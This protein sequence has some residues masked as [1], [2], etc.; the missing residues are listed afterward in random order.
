MVRI[1]LVQP[2]IYDFNAF[3]LWVRPLGWLNLAALLEA[4]GAE[5]VLADALDRYQP[6]R[7]TGVSATTEW[8]DSG[9]DI[10]IPR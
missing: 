7:G 3:D 5:V 4:A 9:A 10:I 2:P 6:R 8:C 1:L